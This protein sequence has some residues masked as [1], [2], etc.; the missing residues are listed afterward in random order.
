MDQGSDSKEGLAMGKVL[1]LNLHESLI[2]LAV[3]SKTTPIQT[4]KK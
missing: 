3:I 1:P 2:A 4:Q